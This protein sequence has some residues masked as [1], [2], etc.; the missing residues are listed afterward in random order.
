MKE[1][2]RIELLKQVAECAPKE[3]R[4]ELN[5]WH[6]HSVQFSKP[7]AFGLTLRNDHVDAYA[8]VAMLDAMEA[9]HA[10]VCLTWDGIYICS[11]LHHRGQGKTRAEA[12]AR[13]FVKVFGK[14]KA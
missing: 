6:G 11:T 8:I 9:L 14:E 2:E 4:A 5:E 7:P 13:A 12:V 10:P 1:Q 3:M